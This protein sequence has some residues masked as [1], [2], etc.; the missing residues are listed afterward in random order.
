M[1]RLKSPLVER[2]DWL[3]FHS[4]AVAQ[5]TRHVAST[6]CL[7]DSSA[8]LDDSD[9]LSESDESH[10]PK[11]T[12]LIRVPQSSSVSKF[13][14]CPSPISR[15]ETFRPKSCGRV[16]TSAE[17]LS[18]IAEKERKKLELEKQRQERMR[19]KRREARWQREKKHEGLKGIFIG[20]F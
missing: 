13:L 8:H 11:T 3:L 9:H 20:Q 10:F 12:C 14:K 17:N 15:Q 2:V 7:E 18:I 6:K 4:I 16:L 1:H 5:R 19:R